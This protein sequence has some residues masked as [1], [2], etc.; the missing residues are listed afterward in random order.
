MTTTH[1]SHLDLELCGKS[2]SSVVL[3]GSLAACKRIAFAHGLE[4][5]GTEGR[6]TG[7]T[8]GIA[9]HNTADIVRYVLNQGMIQKCRDDWSIVIP[10]EVWNESL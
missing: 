7:T 5:V 9:S 6:I 10:L 3:S 4:I 2:D 8:G 1:L